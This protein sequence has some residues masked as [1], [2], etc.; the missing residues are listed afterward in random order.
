MPAKSSAKSQQAP[1]VLSEEDQ[2]RLKYLKGRL[3]CHKRRMRYWANL[4]GVFGPTGKALR[5]LDEMYELSCD[6]AS[7]IAGQIEALT[8]QPCPVVNVKRTFQC[9]WNN[10]KA[11]PVYL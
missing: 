8:K 2:K 7:N 1:A 4:P 10:P 6:D 3:A 5:R 11:E 9:R